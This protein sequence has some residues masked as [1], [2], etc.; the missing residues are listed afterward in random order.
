VRGEEL[1]VRLVYVVTW[2]FI[3]AGLAYVIVIGLLQ[4]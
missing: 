4:R 2:V 1:S 3:L